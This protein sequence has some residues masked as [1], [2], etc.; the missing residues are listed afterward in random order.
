LWLIASLAPLRSWLRIAASAPAATAIVVVSSLR[1]I[2]IIVM[3]V[4]HIA[5]C[6][7]VWG[8]CVIV[9]VPTTFLL[10]AV[11]KLVFRIDIMLR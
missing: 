1:P 10:G 5:C 4:V 9:A 11:V 2:A 7:H 8:I 6:Y 3:V